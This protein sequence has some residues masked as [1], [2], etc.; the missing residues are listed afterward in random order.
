ML[1]QIKDG[2]AN[3]LSQ[4]E[5]YERNRK[6]AEAQHKRIAWWYQEHFKMYEFVTSGVIQKEMDIDLLVVDKDGGWFVEE[7]FIRKPP[8]KNLAV[9]TIQNTNSNSPGWIHV[10]KANILAWH[11]C[12]EDKDHTYTYWLDMYKL[13]DFYRRRNCKYKH[14]VS[15]KGDCKYTRPQNC[16]VPWKDVLQHVGYSYYEI[17]YKEEPSNDDECL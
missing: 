6:Y 14:V 4:Q 1:Y 10:S 9:E 8:Y 3:D 16:L 15:T 17:S 5:M 7:K 2:G 13:K 12:P 11:Y